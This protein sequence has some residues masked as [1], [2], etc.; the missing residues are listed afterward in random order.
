MNCKAAAM[1]LHTFLFDTFPL[2]LRQVNIHLLQRKSVAGLM[3]N[4]SL[5]FHKGINLE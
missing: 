1:L 3:V 2:L 4:L 5:I